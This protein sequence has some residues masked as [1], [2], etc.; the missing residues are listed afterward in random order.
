MKNIK[1]KIIGLIVL[2]AAILVAN[3]VFTNMNIKNFQEKQKKK[4]YFNQA[5]YT[6]DEIH[7]LTSLIDE[8]QKEYMLL[9]SDTTKIEIILLRD[10]KFKLIN[11][12]DTLIS[13]EL[14]KELSF[15]TAFPNLIRH[16]Q[17]FNDFLKTGKNLEEYIASHRREFTL[18]STELKNDIDTLYKLRQNIIKNQEKYVTTINL[19]D[20]IQTIV[21]VVITLLIVYIMRLQYLN[22]LQLTN[23]L[24][25]SNEKLQQTVEELDVMNENYKQTNEELNALNENYKQANE[26]LRLNLE[27]ISELNEQISVKNS[28]LEEANQT[29]DKFLSII[30]HD[31]KNPFNSLLGFSDLL[32]RNVEKYPLDKT[33]KFITT[34]YETSKNTYNLLENLLQWSRLQTKKLTPNFTLINS[35]S[36][37]Y[38]TIML[39]RTLADEKNIELVYENTSKSIISV[40]ENMIATALRNLITNAIKFTNESGKIEV[41]AFEKQTKLYIEIA[42]NGVGM[43]EK[44]ME[45]LFK[46]GTQVSTIGT[47]GEKGTGLGLILCKDLV[48]MNNGKIFV[49]SKINIGTKFTVEFNIEN[50]V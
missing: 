34:I 44:T 5:I 17:E 23:E 48:E 15:K 39:T 32:M 22:Q 11:K 4:D 9:P 49:E 42:D 21:I 18:I 29:K 7:F 35:N 24:N 8:E 3:L 16:Q 40:D 26:E 28:E 38:E 36:V 47:N 6:I 1:T 19:I 10:E 43:S 27:T 25:N 13:N 46:I 31:L 37:V 20:G 2:I 33:K 45:N 50:K 30:G 14:S 12:L 41:K